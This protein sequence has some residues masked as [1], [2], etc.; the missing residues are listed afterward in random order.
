[1]VQYEAATD[2]L[3]ADGFLLSGFKEAYLQIARDNAV[4]FP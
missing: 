4:F 3:I 1:M 2:A